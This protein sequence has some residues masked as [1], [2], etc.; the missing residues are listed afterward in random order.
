MH[1]LQKQLREYMFFVDL[2]GHVTTPEVALALDCL[3]LKLREVKLLG[4]FPAAKK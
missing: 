2:K 3:R 1:S 4:S